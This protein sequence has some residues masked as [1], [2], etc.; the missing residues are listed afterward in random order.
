MELRIP[1]EDLEF[2]KSCDSDSRIL[3]VECDSLLSHNG[4]KMAATYSTTLKSINNFIHSKSNGFLNIMIFQN[5]STL[6]KQRK[7]IDR[8]F[9]DISIRHTFTLC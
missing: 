8:R 5:K 3:L 2:L 7:A 4:K 1:R 6:T 9:Q